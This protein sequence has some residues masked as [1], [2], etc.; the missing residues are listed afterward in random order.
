MDSYE[1]R[2][3]RELCKYA[4]KTARLKG[5]LMPVWR[6][7][8]DWHVYAKDAYVHAERPLVVTDGATLF[9]ITAV[10][11]HLRGVMTHSG[12]VTSRDEAWDA[13][14]ESLEENAIS[15]NTNYEHYYRQQI[16]TFD[17]PIIGHVL[18]PKEDEEVKCS[19]SRRNFMR[20]NGKSYD[21]SKLY[22]LRPDGRSLALKEYGPLSIA[23]P[24]FAD[25]NI[26]RLN[27]DVRDCTKSFAAGAGFRLHHGR[28]NLS[29]SSTPPPHA[30]ARGILIDL[31]RPMCIMHIGTMGEA[32]QVSVF[33][34]EP[35]AA[36]ARGGAKSRAAAAR[37]RKW[38]GRKRAR[39]GFV[40]TVCED[41]SCRVASACTFRPLASSITTCPSPLR[42]CQTLETL[43]FLSL[44]LSCSLLRS[45][46]G[47]PRTTSTT[48]ALRP[49]GQSSVPPPRPEHCS[50]GITRD[51]L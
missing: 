7:S 17:V 24:K 43:A 42:R 38:G 39:N 1:A 48:A 13:L 14:P 26:S 22:T 47:L 29:L 10:D 40:Y 49:A 16:T 18:L 41:V 51:N 37:R 30:G 34:K 2:K 44:L 25:R 6:H 3:D 23:T 28:N 20:W 32:P 21:R 11:Q 36:A 46:H 33:P 35:A 45:W 19:V 8:K 9:P 50:N 12:H 5:Q 27:I 31:H 15:Q 4:G